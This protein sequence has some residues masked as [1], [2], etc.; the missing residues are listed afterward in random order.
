M[1]KVFSL[2]AIISALTFAA[3]A[4]S[5]RRVTNPA[6]PPPPPPPAEMAT[7]AP[8]ERITPAMNENGVMPEGLSNHELK[9]ID[10]GSFKL[11]D[12]NGKILVIN[13]WATWCGPCRAEVPD[14]EKVRRE[15]A[16]KPVEFIGLTT[17]DPRVATEKVKQFVRDFNFGFRIGWADREMARALMNGKSVIPQT[18]VISSDGHIISHWHGYSRAESRDRL[19]QTI[20]KALADNPAAA[21]K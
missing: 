18:I 10:K 17:E 3:A 8:P 2:L 12:F 15:F 16:G 14:Y 20:Q 11:S 13:L 6:P 19:K 7:E 9:A 21:E 4:Q 1:K 5:G